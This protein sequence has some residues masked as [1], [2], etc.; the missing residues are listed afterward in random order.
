MGVYLLTISQVKETLRYFPPVMH[1]L[2]RVA[3]KE[4]ITVGDRFFKEGVCIPNSV[5]AI[6]VERK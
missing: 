4:G 1:G 3:P 2:P 5:K 6:E